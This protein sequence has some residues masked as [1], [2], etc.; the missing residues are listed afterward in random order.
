[1][2]VHCTGCEKDVFFFVDGKTWRMSR[3]GKGQ[4]VRELCK[5]SGTDDYNLMHH[6]NYNGHYKYQ[7]AKVQHVLQADGMVYSLT[8]LKS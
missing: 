6:A 4:A 3:P 2:M 7:G 1:M 5:A 8:C